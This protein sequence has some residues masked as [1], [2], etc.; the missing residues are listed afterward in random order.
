MQTFPIE[1]MQ[2]MHRLEC[3]WLE[4]IKT[5]TNYYH[6]Y[7]IAV[8]GEMYNF[9]STSE[10]LSINNIENNISY[11]IHKSDSFSNIKYYLSHDTQI[12]SRG[13]EIEIYGIDYT[14]IQTED[15]WFQLSTVY[16]L[17]GSYE[18]FKS[19]LESINNQRLLCAHNISSFDL[20]VL[21]HFDL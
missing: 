10:A 7:N 5:R 2:N 12:I 20:S 21:E 3:K 4:R 8:D 6:M 19:F 13:E 17:I 1:Y 14:K 18:E 15:D 11:V 9:V 16:N